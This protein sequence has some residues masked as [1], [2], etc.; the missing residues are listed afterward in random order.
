MDA[1]SLR[2]T[3]LDGD[4]TLG[5]C[6]LCPQVA[7][8]DYDGSRL[9]VR[10]FA[11]CEESAV[12]A[13]LDVDAVIG[14]LEAGAAV[15][16]S[17]ADPRLVRRA[18][19]GRARP[20]A[21]TRARGNNGGRARRVVLT[22]ASAIA[23]EPLRWLWC[24]R[25][26]LRGL[27]LI[28]GEPG[29]GKST[30]TVELAA[31]VTRGR[32]DGDL[33]GE[34]RDVLVATAEDHF[35][36]VVWGRLMAAGAD[37]S[38]VHRVHVEDRDGEELLTLPDDVAEIEARC[39]ELAA[40]GR[41]V[42]LVV[43][44]P[45]TAFI[46]GGVDTHRDAA[47]RRVLAPLA[48]LAERQ[49]LGVLGVAHLNKDSTAKLLARVGGSVAFGAAPRS[50]LAFARHPDD[51][52]GEQGVERVIVHAKSNHGRY[53]PSLA[54][55]I[56]PREV[57]EVGEV[58]RLV[59]VGECD[60][61]PRTS[62][63]AGV[64]TSPSVRQPR[65]G[66]PTSWRRVSGT[67]ASRSRHEPSPPG[68]PKGHCSGQSGDSKSRTAVRASRPSRS[69]A[70]QSR[71]PPLARLARLRLARLSEPAFQSRKRPTRRTVAPRPRIVARLWPSS[72]R[73]DGT[74]T[75]PTTRYPAG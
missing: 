5:H 54:A 49:G 38:R 9:R 32:L 65:S 66:W 24:S 6:P 47:V 30:L 43:V 25:L 26:P 74:G 36:S 58:S 53:A 3:W 28:A 39:E 63:R 29:L 56:E 60:V 11:G 1:Q 23:S 42:A 57:S 14:E 64:W 68:T 61:G 10:C 55:R 34:A 16:P 22:P 35:A 18:T 72:P 40:S 75:R 67:R 50:V 44:D 7:R 33:Y 37:M 45:V 13:N 31:Q 48:G 62:A 51:S 2:L 52:D 19:D 71:Q 41:A 17:T 46:G 70:S 59:I 69:G 4:R 73:S 15:T 12:L 8:F 21:D 20:S 27:S